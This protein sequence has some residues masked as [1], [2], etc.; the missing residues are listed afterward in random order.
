MA[1]DLV[2]YAVKNQK[3]KLSE[4]EIKS[5]TNAIL[6]ANIIDH[7]L[8]M[9]TWITL[10]IPFIYFVSFHTQILPDSVAS[11]VNFQIFFMTSCLYPLFHLTKTWTEIKFIGKTVGMKMMNIMFWNNQIIHA[12]KNISQFLFSHLFCMSMFYQEEKII[13]V[14]DF[15][16]LSFHF[17]YFE[18]QKE[19]TVA[20]D[21][22]IELDQFKNTSD[23]KVA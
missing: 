9:I 17:E 15:F 5:S 19:V 18:E 2:H 6:A 12:P 3:I 13:S 14:S 20:K 8:T 4:Y 1:I 22:I 10:S 7:I 21:N 16:K 11:E 23:K